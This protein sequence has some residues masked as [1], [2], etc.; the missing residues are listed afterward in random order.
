MHL[1]GKAGGRDRGSGW[2]GVRLI[3]RGLGAAVEITAVCLFMCGV[4]V[5]GSSSSVAAVK[6]TAD[7][8][9]AAR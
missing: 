9:V 4:A 7:G 5:V 8:L 1:P 3:E 6:L 2:Q